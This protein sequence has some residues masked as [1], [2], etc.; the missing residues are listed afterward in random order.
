V[1][2]SC[3]RLTALLGLAA[4]SIAAPTLASRWVEV[5]NSGVTTDKVMVDADS[6]TSIDQFRVV[7]V[8]R[9]YAA[10]RVNAHNITLDRHVQRTAF[11]CADRTFGIRTLGFLGDKQVGSGPEISDWRTKMTAVGSD[12]LANRVLAIACATPNAG[13]PQGGKPSGSSS[14]SGIV[15]DDSGDILTNNH[16]VDHCR[17]I[18]VKTSDSKPLV[19]RIVG[20]DAKNDL[21]LVKL[22]YDAPLG[23]PAHF[24]SQAQPARLGESVAVIGFPLTGM[25]STEPKVTFG[26]INSVAGARD[27][28][29]LL[30]ISAPVQPGNSGGPVLDGEG[31]V[32]GVVVSQAS[33]A[34]VAVAGNVPQ[35]VNFAIRGEV[36]QI[37]LAARGIKAAIGHRQHPLSTE[38]IAAVGIK[39]TVLIQCDLQ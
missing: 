13:G 12:P 7:N 22:A 6:V 10:P 15:V 19:A 16:V 33:L 36:A 24:R 1:N 38:A 28:S 21:A 18:T 11:N 35:N 4:L 23:E 17:S 3:Q 37:F 14:G 27:D 34:V 29:T 8:M 31:E 25:L 39:S 30:Q 32:I 26:Q 20:A 2:L 5:G 9:L